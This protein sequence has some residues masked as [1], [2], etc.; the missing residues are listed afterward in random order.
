MNCKFPTS[1]NIRLVC[2]FN[3]SQTQRPP[4]V[5]NTSVAEEKPDLQ[6]INQQFYFCSP[7]IKKQKNTVL[8]TD[9]K[10]GFC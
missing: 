5:K 8:K 7:H 2:I 4:Q 10:C 3:Y 1:N 9:S 6:P